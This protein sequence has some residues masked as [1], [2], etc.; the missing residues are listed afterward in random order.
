MMVVECFEQCST[1]G[2]NNICCRVDVSNIEIGVPIKNHTLDSTHSCKRCDF[3]AIGKYN[4]NL[5]KRLLAQLDN[6]G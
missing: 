3:V 6:G 1:L 4:A 5:S 2:C